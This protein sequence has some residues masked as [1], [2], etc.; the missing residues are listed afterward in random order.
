[1]SHQV[2]FN[3]VYENEAEL[4]LWDVNNIVVFWCKKRMLLNEGLHINVFESK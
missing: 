2:Y 1:M 3:D 4:L